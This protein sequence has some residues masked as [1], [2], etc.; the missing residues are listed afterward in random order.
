MVGPE[1]T[2]MRA[3]VTVMRAMRA[4]VTV[5]PVMRP[6]VGPVRRGRVTVTV[7]VV[8]GAATTRP[9][10]TMGAVAEAV[11]KAVAEVVADAVE[12][13]GAVAV[14]VTVETTRAMMAVT[15]TVAVRTTERTVMLAGTAAIGGLA[16]GAGRRHILL[17]NISTSGGGLRRS[18]SRGSRGTR[19]RGPANGGLEGGNAGLKLVHV[20]RVVLPARSAVLRVL[21]GRGSRR[22]H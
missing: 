14:A 16:I 7:R 10:V 3:M 21:R 2:V 11:A 8:M 20:Q 18:S 9:V 15:V 1:V 13:T 22:G 4:V 6:V 19:G 12:A 17:L 5:R